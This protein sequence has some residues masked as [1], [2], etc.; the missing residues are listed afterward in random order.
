MSDGY[1]DSMYSL[2]LGAH[3]NKGMTGLNTVKQIV[4][5]EEVEDED[6]L[7]FNTKEK[8][9]LD[10]P[11]FENVVPAEWLLTGYFVQGT[12]GNQMDIK[13]QLTT[14]N[15]QQSYLVTALLNMGC[16]GSTIDSNPVSDY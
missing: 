16:T 9:G 7:S 1:L 10:G 3:T 14:L 8:L 4:S 15:T 12:Q 2:P 13:L 6:D 11:L 5:M